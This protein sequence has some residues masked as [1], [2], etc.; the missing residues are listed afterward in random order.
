MTQICL[1]F[2]CAAVLVCAAGCVTRESR[3]FTG[4]AS[5]EAALQA[6]V[7]LARSY[8]GEG[9]WEHAK[10]NLRQAAA[11]DPDSPEVHE[12]FALVHQSAGEHRAA[13]ASF[14]RAL[15]ARRDF[16]RARNNYAAFLFSQGRL[17]EAERELEIVVADALYESRPQAFINLGLCRAQLGELKGAKQAFNRALALGPP[18]PRALLELAHIEYTLGENR[19]AGRHLDDY[20]ALS[21]EAGQPPTSRALWLGIRLAARLED[22]DAEASRV[23]ALRNLY[24][25]STEYRLYLEAARNGEL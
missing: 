20:R 21:R 10:R 23:L 18:S 2:S 1:A 5:P 24:P 3:V 12:A 7:Q 22:A 16:S 13:E 11:I 6:R 15:Q 19:A 4:E 25:E 8:I 9:N 17:R 14:R